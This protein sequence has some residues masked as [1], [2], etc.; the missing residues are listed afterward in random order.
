MRIVGLELLDKFKLQHSDVCSQI[1]SWICEVEE[2]I[3]SNPNDIKKRYPHAS[4]LGNRRVVFN[5]KGNSYR[6]ETKIA[7]VQ[8][9]VM[10]LRAGTHAE[11]S[12][13]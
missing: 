3:W 5:I 7:Y 9:V 10:V 13:W 2:A 6:L 11:Y 4:I 8:Q 12:K 1:D